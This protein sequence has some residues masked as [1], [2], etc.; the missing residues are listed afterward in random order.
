[1]SGALIWSLRFHSRDGGFYVHPEWQGTMAYHA[2]SFDLSLG[3]G[4][5]DIK[6]A[7]MVRSYGYKMQEKNSLLHQIPNPATAIENAVLSPDNLKCQGSAWAVR[8]A[9]WR[10]LQSDFGWILLTMFLMV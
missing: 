2:P 5:N 9:V 4:E 1:V 7:E 3:F 10:K 6:M 8:Y